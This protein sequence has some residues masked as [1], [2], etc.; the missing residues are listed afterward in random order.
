MALN[1][2][3]RIVLGISLSAFAIAAESE[4]SISTV[5]YEKALSFYLTLGLPYEKVPLSGEI[6]CD[7]YK[8][9]PSKGKDHCVRDGRFAVESDA[10]LAQFMKDEAFYP[11]ARFYCMADPEGFSTIEEPEDRLDLLCGL[12]TTESTD[13][14]TER[15]RTLH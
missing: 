2:V 15:V 10:E 4:P 14:I 13:V 6:V 5:R 3:V 9:G 11:V 12:S 1:T 8:D 7:T